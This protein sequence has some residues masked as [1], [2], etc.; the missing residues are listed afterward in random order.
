MTTSTKIG[1]ISGPHA[2]YAMPTPLEQQAYN[3]Q[4][5]QYIGEH[6]VPMEEKP[7]KIK[8]GF[9]F[10]KKAETPIAVPAC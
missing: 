3:P 10:W 4:L 9:K 2:A 5:V 1:E 6:A 8:R 7:R